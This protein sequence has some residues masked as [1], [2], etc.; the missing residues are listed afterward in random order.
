MASCCDSRQLL[1]LCSTLDDRSS[2]ALQVKINNYLQ[3]RT[4]SALVFL[5]LLLHDSD[6]A[7]VQT[8][9]AKPLEREIRFPT[10]NSIFDKT[11]NDYSGVINDVTQLNSDLLDVLRSIVMD[12]TPGRFL[13]VPIRDQTSDFP[14]LFVCVMNSSGVEEDVSA[15]CLLI[16]D[17]FRYTLGSVRNTFLYEEERRVKTQCQSL[18]SVARNL[19]SHLDDVSDLLQEIMAEARNLTKAE[20]CSL[21]LLDPNHQELVAKVFD[22]DSSDEEVRIGVN[23]G[24]A[25]HVATTGELL[26]IRDA[27]KHPLFYKGM[28]KV[29]GFRT[30]SILCFPIRDECGGIVGVAQLCNKLA[31]GGHFTQMDEEAA[32]ALSVYCGIC[33][34]H[35]LAYG[36]VRDA[37]ARSRISN[38]LLMYHMKVANVELKG[39]MESAELADL[40]GFNEFSFSP[41]VILEAD[42]PRHVY[43]MFHNLGLIHK[44]RI[45]KETL[46]RFIL[47]VKKGYRDV[48]YHNWMHAFSVTHFAYLLLRNLHLCEGEDGSAPLMGLEALA[49]LVSCLCHDLDHRG[50]T[51]S[52]HTRHGTALACLYSSE[53][54]V[55]EHHHLS[56]AMC[57]LNT[58]GCNVLDSLSRDEYIR[59]LDLIKDIILATDLASHMAVF[60]QQRRLAEDGYDGTDPTQHSLLLS[61]LM[62]VSDLSD[63]T[64]HWRV[65]KRI[66]ELIY[67]E[68]FS[69]GDLEKSLGNLPLDMMDRDKACIPELQIQ[70]LTN[71]VIPLLQVLQ[72]LFPG[73]VPLLEAAE[74][75]R[76]CWGRAVEIFSRRWGQGHSSID[77]LMDPELEELVMNSLTRDGVLDKE[78][79]GHSSNPDKPH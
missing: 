73:A 46:A 19:F 38:E 59:C 47:F 28:D 25:G 30:K 35:S 74:T 24:I 69:Q 50:T 33:I 76:E 49:L 45:N 22:G 27:Y 56:Q 8:V 54:S 2:S 77:I 64:K 17:C 7:I 11:V 60:E 23:T 12:Q 44:F 18:L 61:L 16:Q 40:E 21:F 57:V 75:N 65:S 42:T 39:L 78:V 66:A 13:C 67:Q 26:N 37:Q 6:E 5:V 29:T 51:N 36:R 3:E 63:Q 55:M 58:E 10:E 72:C 52:F 48:S 62:T 41:R 53:G 68:F 31:R 9:G 43:K 15:S 20:R 34:A 70:F 1:E 4:G 32:M 14:P 79:R 71:I